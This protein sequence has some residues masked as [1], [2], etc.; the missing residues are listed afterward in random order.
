VLNNNKTT[1]R[2]FDMFAGIGGFRAGLERAGGY[3][4]IGHCEIDKHADRAY[5]RL[6]NIKE[7]EVFYEDATT[8]D[9]SA[10]PHFDLL[11]AGF[12]CQSFSIAGR[13]QGFADPRGTLFFEIARVVKARKPT[14]LLLENVP[15]LLSH[16]KGRTFAAILNT[17][18]D[19][20][21]SCEWQIINSSSF[22]PQSRRRV[23][24]VG[25]LNPRCAG[26]ILPIRRTNSKTLIQIVGGRQDSRVYNPRGL[27]K[28]L[29]ARS[30]GPGG[31]TGL[32]FI[33]LNRD[34]QITPQARCLK[35]R[36]DS[37]L[38]NRKA[39]NS[40]VIEMCRNIATHAVLTPERETIRQEG[41][42]IKNADEPMFTLTSQDRHGVLLI[43]E[44]TKRGY[45]EAGVGDSVDLAFSGSNTRRGRVGRDVANTLNTGSN[46]G[47][48]TLQGRIRRLVPR[49]CFRLQGFSD[50]Q[51]D[52]LLDG[53]SDAQAYKQA[54]NAVTVNVIH[55]LGLKI[56]NIH[57]T[58]CTQGDAVP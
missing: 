10:M 49:E 29:L 13:R 31:K 53:S 18:C 22:V 39:E 33:D 57:K 4:C 45:K 2:F 51:I 15:G 19:M 7:S 35:A 23:F 27:S 40:G 54:G 3:K 55:A 42:R 28:T 56:K 46:Q 44:A 34:P 37:G 32:Y 1:I 48:V 12:P 24:I 36:Y 43:K 16:D 50:D 17:L 9:T 8:I 5:R 11:C 21:Y 25:Y 41:R 6:H 20:G 26:K 30:R 52:K 58:I 14:Y 47:V 38:T